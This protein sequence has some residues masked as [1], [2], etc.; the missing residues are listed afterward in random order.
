VTLIELTIVMIIIGLL[1]AMAL[2]RFA[3][4]AGHHRM[5]AAAH[6]VKRDLAYAQSYART[7]SAS[8][9][10]N[11]SAANDSY[12]LVGLTRLD[13]TADPYI[14]ELREDPYAAD[15]LTVN[16]G[17]DTELIYDG[18][19]VPDSDGSMIIGVGGHFSLIS[20]DENSGRAR[21]Q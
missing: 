20:V 16:F 15:L 17:G 10:V 5:E 2:P 18:Y 7:S 14:V 11:F 9:T 12:E 6:R 8:V 4:V 21:I 19:G 1:A 13:R 3:N